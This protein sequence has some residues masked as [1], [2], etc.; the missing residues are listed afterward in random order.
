M[1]TG[2]KQYGAEDK[3]IVID[4]TVI[5]RENSRQS[6]QILCHFEE[7]QIVNFGHLSTLTVSSLIFYNM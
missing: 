7:S 6:L 5:K 3:I 2:L 4:E 1:L